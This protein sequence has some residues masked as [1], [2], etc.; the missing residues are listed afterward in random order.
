MNL[1]NI[2]TSKCYKCSTTEQLSIKNRQR[3]GN[4]RMICRSCRREMEKMYIKRNGRG[5]T[6]AQ[7]RDKKTWQDEWQ[8]KAWKSHLKILERVR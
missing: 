6:L 8:E 4:L 3:S 5:L 1:K 2:V 7:K